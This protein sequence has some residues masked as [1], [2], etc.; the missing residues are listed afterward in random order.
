MPPSVREKRGGKRRSKRRKKKKT[1]VVLPP[2]FVFRRQ[3][4]RMKKG[5]S[6][7]LFLST[8]IEISG[9]KGQSRKRKVSFFVLLCA[10]GGEG[11]TGRGR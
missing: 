1:I 11:G 8:Y 3:A 4:V 9:K 6:R 10:W 2:R 7:T 5:A